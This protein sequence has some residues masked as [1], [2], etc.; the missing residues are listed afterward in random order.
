MNAL[1]LLMMAAVALLLVI[2]VVGDDIRRITEKRD[3]EA[4][5]SPRG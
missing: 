1:F 2:K 3:R 5:G 4:A